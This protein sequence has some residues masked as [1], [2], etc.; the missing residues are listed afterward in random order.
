[1]VIPTLKTAE[2]LQAADLPFNLLITNC[3][4]RV[5]IWPQVCVC[6]LSTLSAAC[7]PSVFLMREH[8]VLGHSC[9][10][11]AWQ[12][13]QP[14]KALMATLPHLLRLGEALIRVWWWCPCPAAL[15]R[16]AGSSPGA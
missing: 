11:K 4:E 16:Q 6:V 7:V 12:L 3:G 9:G 10:P 8:L 2:T 5:F 1:M 14:L 15:R 13:L